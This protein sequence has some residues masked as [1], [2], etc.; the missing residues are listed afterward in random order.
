[1]YIYIYNCIIQKLSEKVFEK[2]L[3]S[4]GQY[5]TNVLLLFPLGL[6]ELGQSDKIV[7]GISYKLAK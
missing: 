4:V 1:M 7:Y 3:N 6:A 2:P 5:S